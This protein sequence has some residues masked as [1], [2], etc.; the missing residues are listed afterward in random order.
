MSFVKDRLVAGRVGGYAYISAQNARGLLL[1]RAIELVWQVLK[2][3]EGL[4]RLW[5]DGGLDTLVEQSVLQAADECLA[6]YGTALRA[7]A[8]ARAKVVMQ[9]WLALERKREHL[10]VCDVAQDY[11]WLYGT[12]AQKVSVERISVLW[13]VRCG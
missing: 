2:D 4:M 7:L 12:M 11:T 10:W 8:V 5:R 9:E 3:Q 6:D 1:H 13:H